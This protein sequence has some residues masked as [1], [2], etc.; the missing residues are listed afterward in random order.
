MTKNTFEWARIEQDGQRRFDVRIV[1]ANGAHT[2]TVRP[3]TLQR[4]LDVLGGP[5]RPSPYLETT[6]SG[7]LFI[8]VYAQ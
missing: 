2:Y 6:R 1:R 7:N 5:G 8:E 3:Y 4:L